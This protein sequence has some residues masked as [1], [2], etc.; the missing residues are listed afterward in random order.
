LAKK[1]KFKQQPN[2]PYMNTYIPRFAVLFALVLISCG[3][4]PLE[5]KQKELESLK[6][7]AKAI[8]KQ[9]KALETE[10]ALLDTS[11]KDNKFK[12][13]KLQQ[14]A[15]SDFSHYIELQGV[16]ESEDN[17]MVNPKMGGLITSV[18]VTE[19][20]TVSAGQ[21]LATID[22]SVMQTSIDE[23]ENQLS[24]AK[25]V[26][27]KQ[28]RLWDQ[29]IGTEIQYLQAKNNKDALEKRLATARSQYALSRIVAPFGG[30]V[31]E[32]N[33]KVGETAAPGMGGIRVVNMNKLKIVA[34][35]ADAYSSALKKGD[36]VKVRL[37]DANVEFSSVISY[38]GLNVS[39]NSR[40]FEIEIKI[41]A[42]I[43]N[44]RP[45]LMANISVNDGNIANAIVVPVNLVQ[46]SSNGDYTIMVA[47]TSNGKTV[48]RSKTVKLGASYNQ[49][50]VISEGLSVKDILISEGNDDL[51]DGQELN[52]IK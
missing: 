48:A 17:V 51:I 27:E 12:T 24:L 39:Q 26:F 45:N 15:A 2:N 14:V 16:L 5:E 34:K 30:I 22:N 25:T 49:K 4:K 9:I 18:N 35:V 43:K 31:D 28:K 33:I 36:K 44:L 29:N 6:K 7:E 10:I 32:I 41:P 50:V 38:A 13:V 42:N 19:G 37:P 3:K 23:I 20:Q 47:E 46:K 8:Q 52:I 1:S 40:T 11:A 21:L